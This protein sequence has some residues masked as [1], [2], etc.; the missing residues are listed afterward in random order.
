MGWQGDPAI[1]EDALRLVHKFSGGVPR[2][3]NLICHRLF[4]YGGLEQKHELAGEDARHVIEELHNER[5]LSPELSS[6]DLS[7]EGVEVEPRGA[8]ALALHLPRKGGFVVTEQ[9]V[10]KTMPP[11][12]EM[13]T[14][15]ST[16]QTRSASRNGS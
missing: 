15:E 16:Q 2:R 10:Q 13:H 11:Q 4:L 14:A 7:G 3:I 12:P 8:E 5:V 6:G 1:T 9:P